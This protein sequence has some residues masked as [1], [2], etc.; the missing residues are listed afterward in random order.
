MITITMHQP[1]PFRQMLPDGTFLGLGIFGPDWEL[2]HLDAD[3]IVRTEIMRESLLESSGK[4]HFSA[5]FRWITAQVESNP[6]LD[7]GDA[8]QEVGT[9]RW[10]GTEY[11]VLDWD[12]TF[13]LWE[14]LGLSLLENGHA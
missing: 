13:E 11:E 8:L 4:G 14:D 1:K 5:L 6:A 2:A 12:E 7:I 10:N 3:G 9:V